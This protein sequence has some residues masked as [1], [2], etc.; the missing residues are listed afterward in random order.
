MKSPAA[1]GGSSAVAF[2]PHVDRMAAV[3]IEFLTSAAK[4]GQFPRHALP[5][6]A[7]AG[8]S[9]VGKSSLINALAQ[10]T[11]IARTS[12]NPGCTRTLNFY[13]VGR[14]L[15]LVDLPGYGFAKVS[16]SERV[17][18]RDAIDAYLQGRDNLAGIAVVVDASI[19]PS[20]LDVGMIGYAC[21]LGVPVIA[22]ATKVDRLARGRRAASL[23]A[24]SRSFGRG[25]GLASGPGAVMP[26]SSVSGEGRREL[27]GWIGDT[28]GGGRLA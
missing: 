12:K 1:P 28:C 27:L 7:F 23:A 16:Q 11:G 24:L 5:E 22:V 8:R 13:A 3:D 2:V 18:W 26:F 9:N 20:E 25:G 4:D 17:D 21:T 10:R 14:R 15:C 6:V 19:P